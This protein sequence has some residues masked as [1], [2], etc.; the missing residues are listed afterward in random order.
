MKQG[1]EDNI[2]FIIVSK[3]RGI[4]LSLFRSE[5]RILVREDKLDGV[6]KVGF[7]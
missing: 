2:L 7:S 4:Y 5:M 6:E 3:S 1:L